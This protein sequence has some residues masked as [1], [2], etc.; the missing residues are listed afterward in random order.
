MFVAS[1]V[2][3]RSSSSVYASASW[4]PMAITPIDQS[5]AGIGTP[6]YDSV[7]P[8]LNGAPIASA[9]SAVPMR[10]G[11]PLSMIRAVS[12]SLRIVPS[13]SRLRLPSSIQ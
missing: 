4:V 7:P 10:I 11:L 9:S 1:V 8:T 5:P 13:N 2:S 3:S 6:R 12:G